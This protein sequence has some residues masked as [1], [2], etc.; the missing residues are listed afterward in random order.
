M[1]KGKREEFEIPFWDRPYEAYY[2]DCSFCKGCGVLVE[3]RLFGLLTHTKKCWVCYEGGKRL[4]P[5]G[6]IRG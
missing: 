2:I 1:Y 6:G 5:S 4:V 3:K